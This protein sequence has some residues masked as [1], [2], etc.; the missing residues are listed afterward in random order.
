MGGGYPCS[1]TRAGSTHPQ[2]PTPSICVHAHCA[3]CARI[4]A[5]LM[6][7]RRLFQLDLQVA[8]QQS[9]LGSASTSSTSTAIRGANWGAGTPAAVGCLTSR[10]GA[11]RWRRYPGLQQSGNS[12]PHIPGASRRAPGTAAGGPWRPDARVALGQ[13]GVAATSLALAHAA[14]HGHGLVTASSTESSG[15][16]SSTARGRSR[17]AGGCLPAAAAAPASLAACREAW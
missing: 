17:A 7:P 2:K 12:T 9:R 6:W 16:A 5:S 1:A 14:A 13:Q 10:G 3:P 11:A 8:S 15:T 4:V